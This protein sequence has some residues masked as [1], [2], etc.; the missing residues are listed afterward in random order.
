MVD[1][2]T[3]DLAST[4]DTDGW[5]EALSNQNYLMRLPRWI[6][7][8]IEWSGEKFNKIIHSFIHSFNFAL[9]MVPKYDWRQ[10]IKPRYGLKLKKRWAAMEQFIALRRSYEEKRKTG[11]RKWRPKYVQRLA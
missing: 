4:F 9:Q 6:F 8:T 5:H 3:S 2:E 10:M 11:F 7:E 1:S